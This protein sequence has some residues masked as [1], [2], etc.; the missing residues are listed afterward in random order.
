[1][2]QQCRDQLWEIPEIAEAGVAVSAFPEH[3]MPVFV[4]L[5]SL[6]WAAMQ[7]SPTHVCS[8]V[9]AKYY[10]TTLVDIVVKGLPSI[11]IFSVIAYGYSFLLGFLF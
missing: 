6:A 8:F 9:A 10:K 11:L 2:E 1:M 5:M 7:I 4:L 3:F